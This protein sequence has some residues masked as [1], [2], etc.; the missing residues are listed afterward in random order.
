MQAY[1]YDAISTYYRIDKKMI[2]AKMVNDTFLAA[3]Q[4]KTGTPRKLGLGSPRRMA[5]A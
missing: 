3:Q 4:S 2:G 1:S 5:L